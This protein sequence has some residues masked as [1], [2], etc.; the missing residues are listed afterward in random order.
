MRLYIRPIA[1]NA[2]KVVIFMAERGIGVETVDVDGLASEEYARV[3]ALRTVPVLE[4]DSGLFITES[5]TI[6]QYLD[7]TAPGPSLFGEGPEERALVAMWERRGEMMLMNPAIE[8]GHHTQEMFAGRLTQYPDWARAHVAQSAKMLGLM[9]ARLGEA[10]FLAGERFTMADLTAF[11]G[12]AGLVGWRAIEPRPGPALGRW[13]G[14]VGT[15]PSMAP[16]RALA[17]QFDLPS[18]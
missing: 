13:L 4:T 12:W 14:A 6:C 8:Y 5:L 9:E 17:K 7:A 3:S 11:L 18:V 1:P 15:R 10:R 2:L 16:L